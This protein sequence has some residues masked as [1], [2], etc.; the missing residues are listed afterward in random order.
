MLEPSVIGAGEDVGG[1]AELF[2]LAQPLKDRSVDY[3]PDGLVEV[4]QVMNRVPDFALPGAFGVSV[5]LQVVLRV[6]KHGLIL[7]VH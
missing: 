3:V 1:G 4:N 6:V 2:Y 7:L 5:G